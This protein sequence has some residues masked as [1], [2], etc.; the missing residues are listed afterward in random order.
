MSPCIYVFISVSNCEC[1]FFRVCVGAGACAHKKE[2]TSCTKWQRVCCS[3]P[4]VLQQQQQHHTLK[5]S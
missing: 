2:C 1:V 5:C 4:A 3:A